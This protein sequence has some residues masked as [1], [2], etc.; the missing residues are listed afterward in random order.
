MGEMRVMGG[1]GDTKVIWN[2]ENRDESKA[3][4]RQ[5]KDLVK[6]KKFAAFLVKKDGEQGERVREF[7]P[8]AG[9][10]IL[11]PPMAGG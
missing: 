2:P 1:H 10:L 5:F 4:E 7:D 11:V 6:K 3:A 9:K 8:Q